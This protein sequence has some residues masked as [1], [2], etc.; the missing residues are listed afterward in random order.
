MI[1]TS[2]LP[3]VDVPNIAVTAA[4]FR[5]A[6]ELADKTAVI[7]GPTGRSY[8]YGRLYDLTRRAAGGLAARG[9][10]P[11]DVL[12]IMAPNVPE[13]AIAFHAAALLGGISTTINPTYTA[14][15]VEYQLND[16]G[17]KLMVTISLFLETA[18]KGAAQ[19]PVE[20]IFTL[21]PNEDAIP[22]SSLFAADPVEEQTPVDPAR[23]LVTLPYSSGTTGLPKGVMLTHRNLVANLVQSQHALSI[24]P[25]EVV[26]AV[27]PFF[28]IYG[29]QVL[30]NGVLH[31]GGTTVTLPRFDLEQF[32][33]VI[34]DRHVTQAYVVPPIVLAL[35]KH[36]LIDSYDLSSLRRV[37]SGAAPLAAEVAAAAAARIGC[38]VAQGYGLTETS[39]VT[40]AT[41]PGQ[42]KAGSIGVAISN[43]ETRV[44]DP[45]TGGDLGRYEDGELWIRG[46]QVMAGYLNRPEATAITIDDEGWLH[47]GD[48][49]HVDNEDHFFIVDRLKELIKYKGFQVPP[50]ELEGL[51]LTHPDVADA[52]VVP[53]PD[54]EAGEVPKGFVVLKP[55]HTASPDELMAF[56]AGHVAHYKQIRLLELVDEIPKS[57]SGKILRRVLR[58][59]DR[60]RG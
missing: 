28:H 27:L 50:A 19:S 55:G 53:A 52:A 32:L 18:K 31:Y 51:L 39:P 54:L 25:D 36:P 23:D 38:E 34:Q 49:G 47:T 35:A 4:V 12:A 46:P 60:D 22:F 13:Y 37:I 30:M 20:E 40:H 16:A 15:E 33:Q 41:P 45:V 48:I 29:M 42:H 7:D 58:D 3:D 24:A 10:G 2:P 5:Y 11:G 57:A 9:F 59:R 8:T 56:V 1:F 43:T 21:D 17:A 14:E 44:V 26:V 6:E